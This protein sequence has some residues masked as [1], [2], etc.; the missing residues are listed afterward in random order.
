MSVIW[1]RKQ[2]T[3][4]G[5][6]ASSRTTHTI[7]TYAT[8]RTQ[9]VRM[10]KSPHAH[11]TTDML[12]QVAEMPSF[13]IGAENGDFARL[14]NFSR[15]ERHG[16]RWKQTHACDERANGTFG[17]SVVCTCES[18]WSRRRRVSA[19]M[20]SPYIKN[21][22]NSINFICKSANELPSRKN[23]VPFRIH[24][25]VTRAGPKA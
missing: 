2:C 13:A 25:R 17:V 12:S 10:S 3:V 24:V 20:A 22:L 7:S 21:E 19:P 9:K 23:L 15:C 11:V 16:M 4:F 18:L 1:C 5:A 8:R 6:R 14:Q